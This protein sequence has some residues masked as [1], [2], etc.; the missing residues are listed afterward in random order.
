[1]NINKLKGYIVTFLIFTLIYSMSSYNGGAAISST[2]KIFGF[3]IH[4]LLGVGVL[5]CLPFVIEKILNIYRP[6]KR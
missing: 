2:L 1:M 4:M 5:I 6:V 3:G